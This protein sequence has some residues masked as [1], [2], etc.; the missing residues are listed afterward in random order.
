MSYLEKSVPNILLHQIII[1]LTIVFFLQLSSVSAVY[2][3][4]FNSSISTALHSFRTEQLSAT[5]DISILV[6][7]GAGFLGS[8]FISYVSQVGEKTGLKVKIKAFD[9]YNG[10]YQP[11]LKRERARLLLLR[12]GVDVADKDI[13]SRKDLSSIMRQGKLTH[14]VHFACGDEMNAQDSNSQVKYSECLK[15]IFEETRTVQS[16]GAP[17]VFYLSPV[18]VNSILANSTEYGDSQSY[19]SILAARY[20]TSLKVSSVGFELSTVYGPWDRT[21]KEMYEATD[22]IQRGKVYSA[23]DPSSVRNYVYIDDVMKEMVSVVLSATHEAG[24]MVVRMKAQHDTSMKDLVR[25]LSDTA[26]RRAGD[27]DSS[28]SSPMSTPPSPSSASSL[29]SAAAAVAGNPMV[30]TT[31]S[32]AQQRS[33]GRQELKA[34]T[35]LWRGLREY[36]S[37]YNKY[38]SDI[39]PCASECAVGNLCFQSGWSHAATASKA[40]TRGC[41]AVLYLVSTDHSLYYLQPVHDYWE[42]GMVCTVAFVMGDSPLYQEA[43]KNGSYNGNWRLVEIGDVSNFTDSRTSSRVAKLSPR[44]F[45]ARSVR[46]AIYVDAKL[47][48]PPLA[49]LAVSPVQLVAILKNNSGNPAY[50]LRNDRVVR[51]GTKYQQPI[52][53]GFRHP[54][55]SDIHAEVALIQLRL[56]TTRPNVTHYPLVLKQQMA[57]YQSYEQ[58][59]SIYMNNTIEAALLV[60]D[61]HSYHARQF[62]CTW[63]REYQQWSDRDQVSGAFT[64]SYLAS[65][66]GYPLKKGEMYNELPIAK[67]VIFNTT[68][69]VKIMPREVNWDLSQL[70]V[71]RDPRY[72]KNKTPRTKRIETDDE[73]LNALKLV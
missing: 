72:L 71:L 30:V 17:R 15:T 10:D 67:E 57:A 25:T 45:F 53:L 55:N 6:T 68:Y 7:G 9:N 52:M 8:H 21:D 33:E 54:R 50:S 70:I 62:R 28:V 16:Q 19:G 40:L 14:I 60:H 42:K 48:T 1:S 27:S 63:Y 51:A 43:A 61:L 18:P 44:K 37:W 38:E 13:C 64:L 31:F 46:Y 4:H 36:V 32:R 47:Y 49:G 41:K 24:P 5:S 65:K 20:F 59:K 58:S 26:R 35:A 23:Y 56:N 73:D 29:P 39:L 22:R 11:A 2:L 12:H 69:F 66:A 34:S 3:H